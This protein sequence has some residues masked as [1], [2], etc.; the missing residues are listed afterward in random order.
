[1]KRKP[2]VFLFS[3]I[4]MAA[5]AAGLWADVLTLRSGKTVNGTYLGGNARQIDFQTS[6]RI[7]K[8]PV[9]DVASVRFEEPAAKAE[10]KAPEPEKER[11]KLLR[12]EPAAVA[13]A[14]AARGVQVPAGTAITVRM[15]DPVDS[16]LNAIGQTFQATVDEPVIVDGQ[17]VIPRGADVTA[18]LTDSQQSGKISGR[19]ELSLALVSVKVDGKTVDLH[20]EEVESASDSRTAR[21]GKV[22]GGT[23]ALGTIIGAIAGGGKGAAIGAISGAGV[24]TAAQVLTKGQHVRIPSESRLT[25]TLASP[26]QL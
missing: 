13:A 16:E 18:K 12:P 6:E 22:I 14:A 17:T 8:Y 7:E 24:G 11:V 10:T 5:S 4:L 25:F 21:S 19:T 15:I 3:G 2:L 9:G 1:M 26:A 20:S 23:A